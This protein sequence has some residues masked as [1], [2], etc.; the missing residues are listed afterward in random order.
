ML[1][2]Y[3][4]EDGAN[5]RY[6]RKLEQY[7]L[8]CR[9]WSRVLL[10]QTHPAYR[11]HEHVDLT[12][13]WRTPRVVQGPGRRWRFTMRPVATGQLLLQL[14]RQYRVDEVVILIPRK[15]GN[16]G[17]LAALNYMSAAGVAIHVHGLDGLDAKTK[18]GKLHVSTW[19]A[20]KGTETRLAIVLGFDE[21]AK[22]NPAF[23]G[24]SR[25][26]ERL[27]IIQDIDAPNAAL[28]QA[29]K[30]LPPDVT[31][32]DRDTEEFLHSPVRPRER[33]EAPHTQSVV[34][35][36]VWRP[37]CSGRWILCGHIRN[38]ECLRPAFRGAEPVLAAM[39][40]SIVEGVSHLG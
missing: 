32:I 8:S 7:F 13:V 14:V 9:P 25:A 19:H 31:R 40:P 36:N 38:E 10:T 6:L 18:Q 4:P 11:K 3:N 29:L 1:Y 23:V 2:D 22:C 12:D 24:L 28:L 30:T 35:L 33:A 37:P 15:R 21:H 5:L 27:V 26:F 39:G 20:A 17:L 34:D 16:L